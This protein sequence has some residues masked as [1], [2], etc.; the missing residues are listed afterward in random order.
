MLLTIYDTT[1]DPAH[2][3]VEQ[4]HVLLDFSNAGVMSVLE[5]WVYSNYGDRTYMASDGG[6]EIALPDG[7]SALRSNSAPMK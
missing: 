5:V 2:V 1:D 7:A 4:L 3:S 6:V